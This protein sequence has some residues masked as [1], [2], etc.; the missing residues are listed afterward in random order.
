[1]RVKTR[2]GIKEY[3][4][5]FFRRFVSAET[6]KY[7][8]DHVLAMSVT[9]PPLNLSDY[10]YNQIFATGA[11]KDPVVPDLTI[12][13]ILQPVVPL[14]SAE[15]TANKIQLVA[16][17]AAA[18]KKAATEYISP[19]AAE[20]ERLRILANTITPEQAN[21]KLIDEQNDYR[22]KKALLEVAVSQEKYP[23]AIFL[24]GTKPELVEW[25]K[26]AADLGITIPLKA[27]EITIGGKVSGKVFDLNLVGVQNVVPAQN[28]QSQQIG[29][30][31]QIVN[32]IYKII[33]KN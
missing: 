8:N 32:Y 31:D 17:T 26:T 29:W 15:E 6:Y 20:T 28:I 33:Y 1:M 18:E 9:N 12:K 21:Q 3:S 13:P 19:E 10:Y 11:L 4:P 16:L 2:Y 25:E 22:W 23:D 14:I 27:A 5:E 30:L 7:A 24:Q